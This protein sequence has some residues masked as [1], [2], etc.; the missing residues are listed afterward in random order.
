MLAFYQPTTGPDA[1]PDAGP[2][3]LDF[4]TGYALHTHFPHN[5]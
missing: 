4:A 1:K 2:L 3:K 5:Y